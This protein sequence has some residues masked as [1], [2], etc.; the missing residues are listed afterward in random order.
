MDFI[1][2][3]RLWADG[4]VFYDNPLAG[5]AMNDPLRAREVEWQQ[6]IVHETP[7][8][9]LI[10]RNVLFD[11]L[12]GSSTVT[13]LHT[14]HGLKRI[15]QRGIVY[16]SGGC[17]VGSV[18]C[19]PL[20]PD[21][22]G[23]RIHNLG[24]YV[25]TR[26]APAFVARLGRAGGTPTPLII[27]I[28]MPPHA[29]RGLAGIDYLRLGGIHLQIFRQLEYLLS[30]SERHDLREKIVG[31]IK[32]SAAFLGLCATVFHAGEEVTPA[33]FLP[34]LSAATAR[35]P[36]L[37]YLCFEAL[38]EYLMLHSTSAETQQLK[39]IGE[40]NNRLYKDML[41][42]AFPG[43]AG[44]FNLSE[45]RPS[46]DSLPVLLDQIDPT[47]DSDHAQRYLVERICF[48][49]NAR[50]LGPEGT[51]QDWRHTRWEFDSLCARVAPLVG[52]LIHRELR[53]F[54]RYPDFYFYYDQ[55]KALQ[56]WN[57][58]NHMDIVAPFNGTIPKGEVGINPAYPDLDYS[59]YMGELAPNGAIHPVK[60]LDLRITPRLVDLKYTLMRDSRGG[61]V[62][63]DD[64]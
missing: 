14:T 39:A 4:H 62:P 6:R 61:A 54:G 18:Y 52:H 46:P 3:Y 38:S 48:L 41:F 58:W 21:G 17:L 20:I 23:Y 40:L 12:T 15:S 51:N 35:L 57:Y 5:R 29:Y 45:F 30:R 49:V 50:L 60:Q 37:G 28:T 1:D 10:Q 24:R 7:N 59:I 27:K 63:L 42:A 33:T 26:E 34:L 47:I 53:T 32:N 11:T 8:G 16:P 31:R 36:I 9:D 19:S 22:D 55:H 43:M 25:L 2:S 44:A 56:A 64:D 13:L